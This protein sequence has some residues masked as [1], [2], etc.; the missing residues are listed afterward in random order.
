MKIL[1]I[2]TGGTI[3]CHT[4]NHKINLSYQAEDNVVRVYQKYFPD[5]KVEF[6]TVQPLYTLSENH[7]E[8]TYNRLIEFLYHYDFEAYDGVIMTHGSDTLSYTSALVGMLLNNI[9]VPFM[10]TASDYPLSEEKSNGL[11]NFSACVVW[12]EQHICNG[13]FTVY[14][15]KDFPVVYLSTRI[16]EA[17]PITDDFSPF[18]EGIVGRLFNREKL[19]F[20]HEEI[21]NMLK[22]QR[23]EK[24]FFQHPPVIQN[25]VLL[26]KTYP[27]QNFDFYG[28]ENVSAVLIYLYHSATACTAGEEKNICHF[29]QK[30][31]KRNI[32]I[33]TA[34]HKPCADRYVTGA[35]TD[36]YTTLKLYGISMESAYIKTLIAVNQ[37]EY[38]VETVMRENIFWENQ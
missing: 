31:H 22:T 17:D 24:R 34:S 20:L 27:N 5:S 11:S 14:G 16:C 33:Y 4:E 18:G 19:Y 28:I 2:F 25:D 32:P 37:H 9:T 21:V 38:P 30:C 8:T 36:N 35:E 26:I 7:T 3:A 29:M 23:K 12:I 6:E 15:K 10:I 1:V 13:V